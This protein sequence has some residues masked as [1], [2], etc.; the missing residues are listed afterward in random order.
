[1]ITTE[2]R[3]KREKSFIQLAYELSKLNS[4]FVLEEEFPYLYF[5]QDGYSIKINPS[6]AF[7][8]GRFGTQSNSWFQ[9]TLEEIPSDNS[10]YDVANRVSLSRLKV[11]LSIGLNEPQKILN[12][13]LQI[14]NKVKSTDE[15]LTELKK[16]KDS[17]KE[18]VAKA[19]REKFPNAISFRMSEKS[20]YKFVEVYLNPE[21]DYEIA[22]TFKIKTSGQGD[23]FKI[24][25]L[26]VTKN[27]D[28]LL[29]NVNL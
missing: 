2:K 23:E 24:K 20:F 9:F 26:S 28:E 17:T 19:F 7:N 6:Y 16:A 13:V 10:K 3:L 1:M 27:C 15:Y 8:Y 12:K 4:N 25:V 5:K 11:K 22:Y 21:K 18:Y 29:E 14:L